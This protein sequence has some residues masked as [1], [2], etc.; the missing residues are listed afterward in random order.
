MTI[1]QPN[2]TLIQQAIRATRDRLSL[3]MDDLSLYWGVP[4]PT[5]IKWHQG[6]RNPSAVV[7]RLIEVLGMVEMM[8]PD[9]HRAMVPVKNKP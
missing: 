9:I 1:E 2:P 5:L 4:L 8:A 3:S 6:D 7:F